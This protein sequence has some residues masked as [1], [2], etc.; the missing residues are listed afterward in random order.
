VKGPKLFTS[1]LT[2]K[3]PIFDAKFEAVEKKPLVDEEK[4]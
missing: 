2:A 1:A 3:K 4:R